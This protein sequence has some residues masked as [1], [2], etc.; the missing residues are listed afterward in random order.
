[1]FNEC[2]LNPI[3]SVIADAYMPD[4][5]HPNY[6]GH[7]IMARQIAGFV[8]KLA[9]SSPTSGVFSNPALENSLDV[10]YNLIGEES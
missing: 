2:S 3:I 1:M 10:L 8:S 7:K 9:C 5:S 4:G 6:E